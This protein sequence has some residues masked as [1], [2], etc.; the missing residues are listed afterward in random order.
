M[1]MGEVV[2]GLGLG[3]KDFRAIFV[4]HEHY[5]INKFIE[6]GWEFGGHADAEAKASDK[7]G[8]V[9]GEKGAQFV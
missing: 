4:F 6:S 5:T 2:I 1:K 8:A 3:V 9:G 7:G